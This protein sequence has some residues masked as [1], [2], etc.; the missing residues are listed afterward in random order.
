LG[1]VFFSLRRCYTRRVQ[2]VTLA[3]KLKLYPSRNKADTLALLAGL[4]RRAHTECTTLIEQSE[5]RR[6]PS[7][8]GLGEFIGRA[9]RRASLDYQ[10]TRKAGHTP[11]FLKAELIDSAEIQQPRQAKGFDCWIM[12]RGTTTSRG[13]NGG[14][15][16]PAKRHVAINRTL[17]LPGAKLNESAEVFRK[18]GTWYARVSVT[19]PLA[20]LQEPKG[21]L[22]CDVGVRAAVTRS[23]GH[24]G[25]DL[26]LILKRDK[27]RRAD[28]QRAGLER[29][30]T[31]SPQRQALAKEA[32]NV[33]SVSQRSGRG[34]SLEDPAR[35]IR[36]K[37]WAGRYFA[38]RVQVLA[39][40]Y[41][42]A[43]VLLNPSGTSLTCSRCGFGE[44]RQRHKEMF[45]CWQCGQTCNADFNASVNLCHG[46][47]RVTAVSPGSLS[48]VPR[49]GGADE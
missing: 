17:A 46:A 24:Q 38:S 3:Y 28:Q 20:E 25:P 31:M 7:T 40:I 39:A 23:D 10:R 14:F 1:W 22:G 44:K 35:M 27:Q 21:W 26:R 8:T 18:N 49:G 5:Q 30:Y 13:K 12:M 4:F 2:P 6:C 42:V 47:Y 41:G 15:Y 33:V 29:S 36:Y 43:V 16:I 34:V 32:R 37:Q 9:Y 19:I 48:L 11:G 45:R